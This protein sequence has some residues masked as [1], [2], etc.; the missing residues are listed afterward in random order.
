MKVDAPLVVG[1]LASIASIVSFTPQA[2]RIIK[3]RDV[4]GLSAATYSITVAGFVLWTTYGI[5]LGKWPLIVTNL[6]CLLL[7][8][9]ILVMVLLPRHK[10]DRVADAVDP[11]VSTTGSALTPGPT[12]PT[13]AR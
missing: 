3:T 7:S 6:V 10:R 4:K 1:A 9:F 12:G 5:L 8:L 2:W 13:V 11:A